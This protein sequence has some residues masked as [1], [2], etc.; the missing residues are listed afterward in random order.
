VKS[1]KVSFY[2]NAEEGSRDAGA[3]QLII[4]QLKALEDRL[5][6]KTNENMK[7]YMVYDV[8]FESVGL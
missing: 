4:R 2:L 8:P 6:R 5:H 1:A 3:R 7:R